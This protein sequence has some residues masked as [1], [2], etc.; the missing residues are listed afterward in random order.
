MSIAPDLDAR[1]SVEAIDRLRE[2]AGARVPA[3][4]IGEA[5]H[6]SVIDIRSKAAELGLPLEIDALEN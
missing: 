2:L 6:R 4:V 3:D 5:M 1:W